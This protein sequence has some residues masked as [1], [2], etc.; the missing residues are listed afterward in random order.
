[1]KD[2]RELK[3]WE[4]S[5]SLTLKLYRATATFPRNELYGLTSQI[6]RASASISTNIAEG[7]GRPRETEFARFLEIAL[8]SSSDVEYLIALSND[9]K[10]LNGQDYSDL[11]DEA[12]EIKRMLFSL[13]KKLKADG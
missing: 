5:H 2:F 13:Y 8:G 12:I 9:L 4:K 10:L 6:R 11:S 1:M 7:C 3:V